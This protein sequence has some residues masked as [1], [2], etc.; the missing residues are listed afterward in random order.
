MQKLKSIRNSETLVDELA[1][2]SGVGGGFVGEEELDTTGV[3]LLD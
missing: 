3:S 2:G 1:D